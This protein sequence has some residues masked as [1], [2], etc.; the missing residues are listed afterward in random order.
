MRED[1][2]NISF[3]IQYILDGG[4]VQLPGVRLSHSLRPHGLYHARLPCPSQSPAVCPSSC[5]LNQWCHLTI[6]FSVAPFSFCFQSLPASG[7]FPVNQ[8]FAPGTQSIGASASA[9]VLPKRIQC[10]YLLRLTGLISLLSKGLSRVL[11]HR[12]SK[13][14][15]FLCSVFFIVQLSHPYMIMK[16][17]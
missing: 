2:K 15:I 4:H 13:P 1:I 9:S 5:L 6:S 10:W 7:A 16:K 12:S 3:L 8:L 14:S 11:Q 17:P